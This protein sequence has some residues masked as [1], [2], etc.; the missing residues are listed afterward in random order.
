MVTRLMGVQQADVARAMQHLNDSLTRLDSQDDGNRWVFRHPTVTDAFAGI[1][2][3]SP[4]LVELYVHGA[5]L[6]RLYAQ[7]DAHIEELE[8]KASSPD[9]SAWSPPPSDGSAKGSVTADTIFF[10]VDD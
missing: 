9:G 8:A 2:A 5:K 10:D 3:A 7:L 1:V 4:E 6:D